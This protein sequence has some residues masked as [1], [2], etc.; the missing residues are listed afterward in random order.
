MAKRSR[1]LNASPMQ[2]SL[3][4]LRREGWRCAIT[5]NWNPAV[6]RRIDLYGCIDILAV[7]LYDT[8][9]V[10]TTSASNVASRRTKI[11]Q[12]V[13]LPAL[14]AAGWLIEIHGWSRTPAGSLALTRIPIT[15]DLLVDFRAAS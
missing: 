5:E 14:L 1:A 9:A 8:L 7:R 13:H 11:L 15:T 6:K 10:Q 12:N 2:E 3:K 4:R